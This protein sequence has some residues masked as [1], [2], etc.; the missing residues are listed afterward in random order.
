ML[1]ALDAFLAVQRRQREEMEGGRLKRLA[2]WREERQR[3][4]APVQRYLDL[5]QGDAVLRADE[6]FS[7]R[8]RDKVGEL[9]A[10]EA[11]LNEAAREQYLQLDRQLAELRRGRKAVQ[12]YGPRVGAMPLPRFLSSRT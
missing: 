8:V 5:L 3:L 9:V 6:S 10:A 4:F 12:G 11:R 7:A 2:S 1:A